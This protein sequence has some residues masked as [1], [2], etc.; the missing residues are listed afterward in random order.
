MLHFFGDLYKSMLKHRI[1]C[2]DMLNFYMDL[3][4]GMARSGNTAFNMLDFRVDHFN[5]HGKT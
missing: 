5:Q 2:F 3:N 4:T 1:L